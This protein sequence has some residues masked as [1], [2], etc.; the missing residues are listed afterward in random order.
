MSGAREVGMNAFF[1]ANM[2]SCVWCCVVFGVLSVGR[3]SFVIL[4]LT[5]KRHMKLKVIL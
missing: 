5:T 2:P 3:L 1:L 4:G